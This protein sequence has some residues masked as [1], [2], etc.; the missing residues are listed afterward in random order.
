M[1]GRIIIYLHTYIWSYDDDYVAKMLDE[2]ELNYLMSSAQSPIGQRKC[3][4][5]LKF[6]HHQRLAFGDVKDRATTVGR[7]LVAA[8]YGC[9][10]NLLCGLIDFYFP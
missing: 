8:V 3:Y 7:K 2:S 9:C 1:H 10:I 5:N 6:V 4:Y